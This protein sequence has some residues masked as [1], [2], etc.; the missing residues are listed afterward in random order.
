MLLTWSGAEASSH[1]NLCLCVPFL[2]NIHLSD[3]EDRF[4]KEAYRQAVIAFNNDEVPVG[5]VIVK[6]GKIISRGHNRKEEKNSAI[7]HAEIE[8]INK[9]TKKLNNWYLK[10]C[11]LYVTLEPCMMC[12]G[13]IINSRIKKVFYGAKDKKGG[14]IESNLKINKVKNLNHYPETEYIENKNCE[15]ILKEFF[16]KKR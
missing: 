5:C 11:E 9:A 12:I 14:A 10:D 7:Y 15:Q 8:A 1:T 16:K 13:A 3:M 6:D 4:M 2:I